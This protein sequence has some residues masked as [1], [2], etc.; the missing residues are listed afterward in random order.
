MNGISNWVLGAVTALLALVGLY[1]ASNAHDEVGYYGG[2]LFFVF[3]VGL[4]L[5]Q[6]KRAFN[7]REHGGSAH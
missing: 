4:I 7:R 6:I 5:Y 2:L 3:A 1:V